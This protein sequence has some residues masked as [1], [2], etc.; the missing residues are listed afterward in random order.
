ML[1]SLMFA[2][3]GTILAIG[4]CCL[5]TVLFSMRIISN[6]IVF[7]KGGEDDKGYLF[8][9]TALVAIMLAFFVCYGYITYDH[10]DTEPSDKTEN[11]DY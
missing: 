1:A 2:S 8:F 6:F 5:F 9:N 7:I 10:I 4:I 3:F 11:Y